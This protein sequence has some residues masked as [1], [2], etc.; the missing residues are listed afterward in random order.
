MF[1]KKLTYWSHKC[2]VDGSP[3]LV[4]LSSGTFLIFLFLSKMKRWKCSNCLFYN[5]ILI[6]YLIFL[7]NDGVMY[8][9]IEI[10]IFILLTRNFFNFLPNKK[11]LKVIFTVKTNKSKRIIKVGLFNPNNGLSGQNFSVT[12]YF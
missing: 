7:S 1:K 9:K 6:K 5:F 4:Q 3:I 12:N 2:K 8:T 11:I 10:G